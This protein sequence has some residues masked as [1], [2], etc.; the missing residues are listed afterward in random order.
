MAC[1]VIRF[2]KN[3]DEDIYWGVLFDK[4]IYTLPG[5]FTNTSDFLNEAKGQAFELQTKLKEGT[6]KEQGVS[7]KDVSILS[8]ITKPCLVL[9]QGANYR[10]HM[11]ESGMNPDNKKF[12]MFFTKSAG[13][14]SGPFD[15]IL[16]PKHV[17]LLDYEVELGLVIGK[18]ITEATT[19]NEEKLE[20]HVVALVIGNDVSARDVQVPQ[21]QFFK[22]KSYRSFCPLGPVL[23]L[24]EP[25]EIEHVHNLD[26]KLQVNDE[27]RQDDNTENLV[28]KPCETLS[29]FSQVS[30]MRVGDV[31][32]TGTPAGC[33]LRIPSPLIT[34]FSALLPEPTKWKMFVKMQSK[35]PRYLQEGDVVK[36]SIKS[37]NGVID[38]GM[39]I[40]KVA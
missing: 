9:C 1:Q 28:F 38:L 33:A 37:G 17:R 22:G 29:E 31:V 16:K 3:K 36:T 6:H 19:F 4:T 15:D 35:N 24:L 40:N 32:L 13:S 10:Q 11:I 39:Q 21:M 2:T 26:L 30:D 27:T 8:P 18:D 5:S 12:N 14:I 25:G 23:C 34:K 20:Q 7:I